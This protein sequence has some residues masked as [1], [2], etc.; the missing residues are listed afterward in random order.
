MEQWA[1]CCWKLTTVKSASWSSVSTVK[2]GICEMKWTWSLFYS[3]SFQS[4]ERQH[5]T[6]ATFRYNLLTRVD[7]LILLLTMWVNLGA[8]HLSSNFLAWYQFFWSRAQHLFSVDCTDMIRRVQNCKGSENL[9]AFSDWTDASCQANLW[10]T[11]FQE[12]EIEKSHRMYWSRLQPIQETRRKQS[13]LWQRLI[14][15]YCQAHKVCHKK[16]WKY[17]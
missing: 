10:H 1:L 2:I 16:E 17:L 5:K 8:L 3:H 7:V 14:L 12:K 13:A 9:S 15:D 11:S 6:C 4:S